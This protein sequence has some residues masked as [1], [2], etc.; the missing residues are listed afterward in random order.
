MYSKWIG[1][2]GVLLGELSDNFIHIVDAAACEYTASS[3]FELVG[4]FK[5]SNKDAAALQ[6][7]SDQNSI[8]LLV[9]PASPLNQTYFELLTPYSYKLS[10]EVSPLD[11][12]AIKKC[13][14]LLTESPTDLLSFCKKKESESGLPSTLSNKNLALP[15]FY[16]KK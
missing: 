4:K 11:L 8:F 3:D 13:I 6:E 16:S 9:F 7:V 15:T 2:E 10:I 1:A 12:F 5:V 14:K